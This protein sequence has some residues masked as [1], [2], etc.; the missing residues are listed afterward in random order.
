MAAGLES[1]LYIWEL[2]KSD[3]SSCKKRKLITVYKCLNEG[4]FCA[5]S[6]RLTVN[7]SNR[8][9]YSF[10]RQEAEVMW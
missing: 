10:G 6:K 2:K 4:S 1:L 3:V 7:Q 9:S 5:Y 8:Q